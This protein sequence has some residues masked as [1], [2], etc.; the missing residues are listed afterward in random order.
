MTYWDYLLIL[1]VS[2]VLWVGLMQGT[3][4]GQLVDLKKAADE[5]ILK[6]PNY[7]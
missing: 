6:R 2:L 3:K 5:T 7:G 1:S 4:I